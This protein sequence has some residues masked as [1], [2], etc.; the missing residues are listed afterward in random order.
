V[1]GCAGGEVEGTS[2]GGVEEANKERGRGR[3]G[4]N[5]NERELEVSRLSD[6]LLC[7]SR[8]GEGRW[9]EGGRGSAKTRVEVEADVEDA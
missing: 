9:W 5:A 3:Q 2:G 4:R 8:G 1:G 6:A 7:P